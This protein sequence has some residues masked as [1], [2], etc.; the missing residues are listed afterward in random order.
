MNEDVAIK[1][2]NNSAAGHYVML[3]V[4]SV[5]ALFKWYLYYS[6]HNYY[7]P[8]IVS[9]EKISIIL[10]VIVMV[11]LIAFINMTKEKWEKRYLISF[12]LFIIVGH[13]LTY[14]GEK[15]FLVGSMPLIEA[16][17]FSLFL[18][19]LI[20]FQYIYNQTGF[21]IFKKI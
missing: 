7:E 1:K 20:Y 15:I 13:V 17:Y 5:A 19:N 2:E 21:T 18:L 12:L 4:F 16:I 14:F 9:E 11:L 8:A 3:F 10:S 6:G